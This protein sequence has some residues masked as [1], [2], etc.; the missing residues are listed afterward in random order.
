MLQI[1]GSNDASATYGSGFY[2]YPCNSTE[3]NSLIFSG[4][5]YAIN[6]ADMNLGRLSD[7]SEYVP[8]TP[9][10]LLQ[11]L[12]TA[13]RSD[14]VGGIIGVSSEYGLPATLAIIGDVFLKSWYTT[15]DYAGSRLGLAPSINNR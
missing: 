7:D 3:T 13:P 5:Q 8:L 1:P 10:Y 12:T 14:C 15:F 9:N 11:N 6:T 4:R 2:T